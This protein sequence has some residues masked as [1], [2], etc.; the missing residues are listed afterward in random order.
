MGVRLC[1]ACDG[2]GDM[3]LYYGE[4]YGPSPSFQVCVKR[5][6]AKADTGRW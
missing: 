6:A 2:D 1:A 4:P 5:L 3:I